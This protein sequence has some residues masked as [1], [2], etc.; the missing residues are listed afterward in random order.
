MSQKPMS[1]PLSMPPKLLS[2]A[3]S[4]T[5]GATLLIGG[6]AIAGPPDEPSV[7]TF[8]DGFS[9]GK[10]GGE[11]LML[12]GRPKDTRLMV[13]YGYA[14]LVGYTPQLDLAPDILADIE[15]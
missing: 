2:L 3:G 8:A 9:V 6:P 11:L 7:V 14:R 10:S 4:L 13:V 5:L 12:V 1:K 15:V